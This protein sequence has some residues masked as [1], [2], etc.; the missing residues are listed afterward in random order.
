MPALFGCFKTC[1][2]SAETTPI[3]RRTSAEKLTLT[4]TPPLFS[5][6]PLLLLRF[7]RGMCAFFVCI[8]FSFSLPSPLAASSVEGLTPAPPSG[9][10]RLLCLFSPSP[11]PP[12]LPPLFVLCTLLLPSSPFRGA[13]RLARHRF[14]VPFA[15]ALGRYPVRSPHRLG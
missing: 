15:S 12:L 3:Q 8:V 6:S 10:M 9:K 4:E 5:L 13:L 7:F 2:A 14:P 11:R 1:S